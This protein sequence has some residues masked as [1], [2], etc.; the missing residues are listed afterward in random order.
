M[1]EGEGGGVH[2]EITRFEGGKRKR[3]SEIEVFE[4]I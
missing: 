2:K 3:E 1:G 4:N